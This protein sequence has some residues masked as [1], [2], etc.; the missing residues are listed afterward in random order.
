MDDEESSPDGTFIF[1]LAHRGY[2]LISPL[3]YPLVIGTVI[4]FIL[5]KVFDMNSGSSIGAAEII[6]FMGGEA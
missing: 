2:A 4:L 5:F 1:R 6:G 3:L